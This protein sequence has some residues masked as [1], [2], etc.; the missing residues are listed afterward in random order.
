MDNFTFDSTQDISRHPVII[1]ARNKYCE[2]ER[3]RKLIID[4]F[5]ELAADGYNELAGKYL[6]AALSIPSFTQRL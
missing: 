2:R 3:Q 4:T 1:E 5:Y 6:S